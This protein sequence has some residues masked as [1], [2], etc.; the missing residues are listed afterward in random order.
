MPGREI[1]R[2]ATV[3]APAVFD[4]HRRAVVFVFYTGR[5]RR[6]VQEMQDQS[7]VSLRGRPS[8]SPFKGLKAKARLTCKRTRREAR[9]SLTNGRSGWRADHRRPRIE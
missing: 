6:F 3:V 5:D 4:P 9:R 7:I 2:N 1:L 8:K